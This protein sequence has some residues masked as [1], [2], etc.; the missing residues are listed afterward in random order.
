VRAVGGRDRSYDEKLPTVTGPAFGTPSTTQLCD[1]STGQQ[2][3]RHTGQ[4]AQTW[5]TCELDAAGL[6]ANTLRSRA[7]QWCVA[8]AK[9][10]AWRSPTVWTLPAEWPGSVRACWAA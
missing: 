9:V 5:L 1:T 7:D 8:V 4:F 6:E 3:V 2:R 10:G